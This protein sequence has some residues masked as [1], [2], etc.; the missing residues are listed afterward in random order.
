MNKKIFLA[1]FFLL[2]LLN[3]AMICA[4]CI[5]QDLSTK[6]AGVNHHLYCQKSQYMAN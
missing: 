3:I 5:L 2:N 1:I 6:K 4:I